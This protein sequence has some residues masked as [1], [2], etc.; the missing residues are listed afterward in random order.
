[1]RSKAQETLPPTYDALSFHI[2]RAHYQASIW[3]Q[4]HLSF[5]D[6]PEPETSGWKLVNEEL[7][8]VLI[9][10]APVPDS[11]LETVP[12]NKQDG[13]NEQ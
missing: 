5:P 12:T 11:C 2:K 6:I 13:R 7:Q 4:A 3:R 9:S 1:M 8:P 10:K